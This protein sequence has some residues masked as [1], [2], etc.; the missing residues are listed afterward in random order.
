MAIRLVL[1]QKALI[2]F[3]TQQSNGLETITVTCECY[4]SYAFELTLD[5]RQFAWRR[6]TGM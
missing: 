3:A 1:L 4:N 6:K 5:Q 2:R